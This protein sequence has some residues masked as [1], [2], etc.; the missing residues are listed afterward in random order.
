MRKKSSSII[1]QTL[2]IDCERSGR[3]KIPIFISHEAQRREGSEYI[4]KPI[5]VKK[6]LIPFKFSLTHIV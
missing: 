6:D 5:L 4:R 2:R 3:D 1:D